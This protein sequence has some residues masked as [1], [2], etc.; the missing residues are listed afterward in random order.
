MRGIITLKDLSTLIHVQ[1]IQIVLYSDIPQV[2]ALNRVWIIVILQILCIVITEVLERILGG[3]LQYFQLAPQKRLWYHYSCPS[4]SVWWWRK[5]PFRKRDRWCFGSSCSS[6]DTKWMTSDTDGEWRIYSQLPLIMKFFKSNKKYI[7]AL[8]DGLNRRTIL[9]FNLVECRE[10]RELPVIHLDNQN[11][12][13]ET[14]FK[15]YEE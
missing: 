12:P 15:E 4:S 13:L 3:Q 2:L 11:N 14:K 1:L 6:W 9:L 5:I 8:L 10:G 7:W